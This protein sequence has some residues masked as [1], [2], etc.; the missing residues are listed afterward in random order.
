MSSGRIEGWSFRWLLHNLSTFSSRVTLSLSGRPNMRIEPLRPCYSRS[1]FLS[2]RSVTRPYSLSIRASRSAIWRRNA[3]LRSLVWRSAFKGAMVDQN[4]FCSC[5]T[6]HSYLKA[7][8]TA[9]AS[10]PPS[11]SLSVAMLDERRRCFQ[12]GMPQ[13]SISQQ[14]LY[15]AEPS[16]ATDPVQWPLHSGALSMASYG[17]WI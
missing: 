7:C 13:H 10:E 8:K 11:P 1:S 15:W 16:L 14:K 4:I 6:T 5:F 2:S 17:P 12:L 3:A 9:R